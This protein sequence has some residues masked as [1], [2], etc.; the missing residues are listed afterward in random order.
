MGDEN[1]DHSIFLH[2]L[3]LIVREKDMRI[4]LKSTF[5][6]ERRIPGFSKNQNKSDLER[7][8]NFW[9]FSFFILKNIGRSKKEITER[10]TKQSSNKNYKNFEFLSTQ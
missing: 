2:P 9:G 1:N 5:T 8:N 7:I 4:I 3:E 6:K 10:P